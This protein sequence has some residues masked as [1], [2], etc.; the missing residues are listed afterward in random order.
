MKSRELND[1]LIKKIFY[2][3]FE[4]LVDP[5]SNVIDGNNINLEV[6]PDKIIKI[7]IPLINELREQNE[8]LTDQEFFLACKHLYNLLPYDEK[9]FLFEWYTSLH[10][11]FIEPSW[12][13]TF[14]VRKEILK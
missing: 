14:K 6:L 1:E 12:N 7:L 5:S 4:F 2:K 3:I 13:F 11:K 9:L 8:T 10:K